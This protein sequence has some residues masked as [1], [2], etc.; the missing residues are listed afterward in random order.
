MSKWHV[1]DIKKGV[2]GELSKIQEELEEAADAQEQGQILMLLF[3]LSDIVGACGIMAN[4]ISG[5]TLDDLV[6]FSKLRSEVAIADKKAL[7]TKSDTP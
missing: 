2:L 7:T 1:R 5:L 6:K 4:K 3:E